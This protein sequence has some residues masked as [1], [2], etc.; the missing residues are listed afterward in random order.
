[1]D[2]KGRERSKKRRMECV[3]EDMEEKRVNDKIMIE[4]NGRKQ[5]IATN[6]NNHGNRP[7]G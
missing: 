4:Q 7:R 5:N 6:P 1:M 2:G 3:K